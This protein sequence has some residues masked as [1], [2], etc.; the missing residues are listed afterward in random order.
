MCAGAARRLGRAPAFAAQRLI[1]RLWRCD[2]ASNHLGGA[3]ADANHR[4][5]DASHRPRKQ[6]A[7]EAAEAA[8][9]AR[10][11]AAA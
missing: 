7:Q 1:D 6:A 5:N 11:V 2:H 9:H 3:N 4:K 10:N 8:L